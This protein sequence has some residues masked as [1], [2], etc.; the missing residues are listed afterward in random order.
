LEKLAD[1]VLHLLLLL[2]QVW[3]HLCLRLT[4]VLLWLLRLRLL[5]EPRPHLT[6]GRL[7]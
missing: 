5:P 4:R 6:A 7:L 3:L 1:C 2:Q